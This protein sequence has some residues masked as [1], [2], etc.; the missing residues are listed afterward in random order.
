VKKKKVVTY[1]RRG[2]LNVLTAGEKKAFRKTENRVPLARQEKRRVIAF[3]I[4]KKSQ[5][6]SSRRRGRLQKGKPGL[7]TGKKRKTKHGGGEH[8]ER[9]RKGK[10]RRF[11]SW[12]ERKKADIGG[13]KEK[14]LKRSRREEQRG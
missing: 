9:E 1:P 6:F 5:H 12:G 14:L 8:Y 4:G 10:A 7:Y 3:R 11:S 2:R 13:D